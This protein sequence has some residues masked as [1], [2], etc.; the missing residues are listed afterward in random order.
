M[1]SN[2][3]RK[4]YWELKVAPIPGEPL[5]FYVESASS[6]AHS[7]IG[8]LSDNE[9]FGACSCEDFI[10]RRE[11][12]IASGAPPQTSRTSCQHIRA[13]FRVFGIWAVRQVA[14]PGPT[15]PNHENTDHT[16]S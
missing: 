8:D 13:A 6:P 4:A 16:Q 11:D 12:F 15:S 2:P 1:P 7:H 9:G 10:L 3:Y 5:R 14:F